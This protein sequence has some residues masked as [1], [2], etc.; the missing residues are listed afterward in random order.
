MSPM[1]KSV[2]STAGGCEPLS[3]SARA[4]RPVLTRLEKSLRQVGRDDEADQVYLENQ[5]RE[6]RQCWTD[7][8][9]GE[10]FFRSLYGAL[11]NYG[12]RPYR[13]LVLSA[14][15]IWLGALVFKLPGAVAHRDK[16]VRNIPLT[17]FDAVALSICYFLPVE[18]PLEEEWIAA[19]KPLTYHLPLVRKPIQVRPAAIANFVLRLSGW[20]VV[21]LALAAV[22][23]LLKTNG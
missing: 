18:F 23:G 21:P 1:S 6:Q 3:I 17:N 16:E 22:T 9:Y 8:N 2:T 14:I 10:W 5:R 20:I 15:L 7:H 11:G 13:L 19:T 12:V 4:D